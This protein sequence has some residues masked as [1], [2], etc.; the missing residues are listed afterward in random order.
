M[1][2]MNEALLYTGSVVTL[3]VA[4]VWAKQGHT[5]FS[6]I[7]LYPKITLYAF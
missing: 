5:C 3:V 6:E 7:Q 2:L 1:I 4:A